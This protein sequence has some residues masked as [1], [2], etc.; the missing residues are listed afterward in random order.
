MSIVAEHGAWVSA[1]AGGALIG[2]SASALM[3]FVGRIAGVSG[4]VPGLL[5]PTRADWPWQAAFAGGLLTGG[6]AWAI[7]RPETFGAIPRPL[8]L[9][10]LAGV[11][12]GFGVSL[13]GG[14]TSGH[15]VCGLS[16]FSIRSLA[17]TLTF[18]SVGIATAAIWR[19]SSGGVQ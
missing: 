19:L 9:I 7:A 13:G 4:I 1:L 15:G 3:F 2:L 6:L 5:R 12:V 14:C 8:H 10:V 17:A 18:M 11:A 16:R